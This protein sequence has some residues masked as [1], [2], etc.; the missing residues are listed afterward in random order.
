MM[1]H[2]YRNP[3]HHQS[4]LRHVTMRFRVRVLRLSGI[5][6]EYVANSQTQLRHLQESVTQWWGVPPMAQRIVY[7]DR[8]LIAS[9]VQK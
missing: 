6:E 2:C 7:E 5:A 8:I 1:H 9:N 4:T 3:A